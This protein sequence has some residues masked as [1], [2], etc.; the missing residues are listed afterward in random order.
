MANQVQNSMEIKINHNIDK[1]NSIMP[2]KYT[3][4]R[5][6]SA[7][8]ICRG[9]AETG[10][11]PVDPQRVFDEL[12]YCQEDNSFIIFSWPKTSMRPANQ[13]QKRKR[14]ILR[15]HISEGGILIGSK[16]QQLAQEAEKLQEPKKR[17]PSRVQQ[18]WS[19]WTY[20]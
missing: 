2:Y 15:A 17:A 10:L 12:G 5:A 18:L 8:N 1:Q 20:T 6:F 13:R 4:T 16:G 3:R 19:S 11:V 7:A 14:D 9:F